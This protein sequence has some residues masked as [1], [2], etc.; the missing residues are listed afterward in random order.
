MTVT[1]ESAL[2]KELTRP[3]G[4]Y[5]LYGDEPALL[6]SV[7]KKL[8]AQPGGEVT[9]LDGRDFDAF[10]LTERAQMIPMLEK[11]RVFFVDGLEAEKL[12]DAHVRELCALLESPPE[13]ACIILS[14]Q[15]GAFD[16]KKSGRAKKIQASADK[17]GLVVCLGHR[18][19]PDLRSALRAR[20]KKQN[21]ELSPE[22]AAFLI[23]TCGDDL[24]VL[25]P[26]ATSCAPMPRAH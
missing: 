11:R 21:C 7:R 4:V 26:N 16:P 25:Y 14:A 3:Y 1:T 6:L 17:G 19:L 5:L 22:A 10:S 24:G 12:S 8:L 13:S 18:K 2:K 20:C 15:K 9:R 23:E